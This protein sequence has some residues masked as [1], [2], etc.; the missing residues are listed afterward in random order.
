MLRR[1]R[2]HPVSYGVQAITHCGIQFNSAPDA[3]DTAGHHE[4]DA[5]ESKP[6]PWKVYCSEHT[7]G[8]LKGCAQPGLSTA[9]RELGP[10]EKAR[11]QPIADD[12]TEAIRLDG[13]AFCTKK[14]QESTITRQKRLALVDMVHQRGEVDPSTTSMASDLANLDMGE[15]TDFDEGTR[16]IKMGCGMLQLLME[17]L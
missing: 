8:P 16:Q 7:K 13:R 11:I 14:E 5:T 15:T 10:S 3:T 6:G 2:R 1:A 17:Q 12:K 9:Y 4:A